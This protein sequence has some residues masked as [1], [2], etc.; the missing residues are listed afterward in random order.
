M[1]AWPAFDTPALIGRDL[2]TFPRVLKAL[3]LKEP[4]EGSSNQSSF[5]ILYPRDF[6][7]RNSPEQVDAME[8]FLD[9]MCKFGGGM[10]HRTI[11]I[12]E[13]WQK[14]APVEEKDPQ[15]YLYNV[16]IRS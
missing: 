3:Q 1:N 11:S 12:R 8:H 6:M 2:L 10:Y 4:V 15:E 7:P 13:D 9:D 14:T 16:S 5:E